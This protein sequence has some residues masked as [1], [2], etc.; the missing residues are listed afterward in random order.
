MSWDLSSYRRE[1]G[2]E[3]VMEYRIL[4]FFDRSAVVLTN[5]F[6]KKAKKIPWEE[7]E[8]AIL[9]RVQW[10]TRKGE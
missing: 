10:R 4:Y 9:R 1:R 3:P 6:V 2:N 8:R 7:I 5:A